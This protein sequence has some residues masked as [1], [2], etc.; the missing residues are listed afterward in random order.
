MNINIERASVT[1]AGAILTLQKLAY[2]SEGEL[3]DYFSIEPLVQTIEELEQ[4]FKDHFVLKAVIDKVIV[5]SVRAYEENET[6]YIGKLIV[7]PD[8]QNRGIGKNLMYNIESLFPKKRFELFTG[9]KS[10]KNIRLYE[11]LG[12]RTF[13]KRLIT[14]DI[15]LIYLEKIS[16]NT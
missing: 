16:R 9:S 6:C 13:Q 1:D 11:K 7:S 4:Q 14:P 5:G 3:Y 8:H 2:R 15:S 10:E 12:Y